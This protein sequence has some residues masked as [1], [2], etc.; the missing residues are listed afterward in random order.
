[1]KR[2]FS[3]LLLSL[4]LIT[5]AYSEKIQINEN[6]RKFVKGDN[7]KYQILYKIPLSGKKIW[8]PAVL[9]GDE[10]AATEGKKVSGLRQS[11]LKFIELIISD[12][13][14]VTKKGLSKAAREQKATHSKDKKSKSGGC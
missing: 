14:V 2:L 4:F 13:Y 5:N 7:I 10:K 8:L 11:E 12:G 1:M 6:L 3:I 9:I